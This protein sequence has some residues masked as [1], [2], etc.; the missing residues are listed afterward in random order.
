MIARG[1][2]PQPKK[3]RVPVSRG[4]ILLLSSRVL[5][6][7]GTGIIIMGA[8]RNTFNVLLFFRAGK[9]KELGTL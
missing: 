2:D 9:L 1:K 8:A 3:Q 6:Q 7:G 5:S 4:R